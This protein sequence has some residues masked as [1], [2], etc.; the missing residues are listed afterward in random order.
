MSYDLFV[1]RKEA[2]PGKRDDFLEWFKNQTEWNTEHSYGDPAITSKEL[3]NLFLEMIKTFPAMN[4]P[5]TNDDTYNDFF[6]DYSIGRNFIYAAFSRSLADKAYHSMVEL[7]EKHDVGFFEVTSESGDIFFPENGKLIAID[8]PIHDVL[9]EKEQK[10]QR[11]WW[12]FWQPR[13]FNR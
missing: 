11:P 1:F 4:G 12:K 8:N 13:S 3:M 9:I 2:A 6:T 5:Y 7:A 10:K